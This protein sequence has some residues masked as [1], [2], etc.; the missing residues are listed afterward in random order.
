MW[1]EED[2]G[3]EYLQSATRKETMYIPM[4]EGRVSFQ[5]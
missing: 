3:W 4:S 5:V 1:E 2:P